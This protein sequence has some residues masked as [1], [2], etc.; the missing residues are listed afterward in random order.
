MGTPNKRFGAV[1]NLS[2]IETKRMQLQ[3]QIDDSKCVEERRKFGQFATPFKLAKYSAAQEL[4]GDSNINR[5]HMDFAVAEGIGIAN[6]LISNPPYV[7][8][9][10]IGQEQKSKLAALIKK[11]DYRFLVLP[12][13]I[14]ILFCWLISGLHRMLYAAG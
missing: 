1:G 3:T 11:R 10:Y 6:I 2:A 12:V 9:H 13:Y 4:C 14:A 5:V 7:R 8:H